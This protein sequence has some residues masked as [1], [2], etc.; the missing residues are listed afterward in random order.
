[1]SSCIVSFFCSLFIFWAIYQGQGATS[2]PSSTWFQSAADTLSHCSCGL[3]GNFPCTHGH[4]FT[5]KAIGGHTSCNHFFCFLLLLFCVLARKA[6]KIQIIKCITHHNNF[7]SC[8]TLADGDTALSQ[9]QISCCY[10][11]LYSVLVHTLS[12]CVIIS[13]ISRQQF[14]KKQ[15]QQFNTVLFTQKRNLKFTS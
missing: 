4:C 10:C 5:G 2:A 12:V 8:Q 15:L 7:A 3:V 1:M 13:F 11:Y 14:K 6:R 9:V